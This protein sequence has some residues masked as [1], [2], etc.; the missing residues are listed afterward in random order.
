MVAYYWDTSALVKRYAQETG[1]QWVRCLT[2]PAATHDYYTMRIT[3]SEMI[4]AV[5]RKV[6]L[7]PLSPVEATTLANYF[8]IHWQQQY[9]ILEVTVQIAEVAMT[10]A[11]RHGLR[12]YDSVHLAA[13]LVLQDVRQTMNLSSLILVSAD[14]EQLQAALRE[15]LLVEN[16]NDYP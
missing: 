8:R 10:L 2:D 13:A 6:R 3:G 14:L 15:G 1:S 12:G 16:P 5:F 4:A 11:E 9:Q 7:G